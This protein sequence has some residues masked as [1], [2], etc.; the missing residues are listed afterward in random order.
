MN[1]NGVI[2]NFLVRDNEIEEL[3]KRG[4]DSTFHIATHEE[5]SELLYASIQEYLN[6]LIFKKNE[7]VVYEIF[8]LLEQVSIITNEREK[9]ISIKNYV[10]EIVKLYEMNLYNIGEIKVAINNTKGSYGKRIVLEKYW[11]NPEMNP[12]FINFIEK[13]PYQ[14]YKKIR[15]AVGFSIQEMIDITTKC[16]PNIKVS[17]EE[18]IFIENPKNFNELNKYGAILGKILQVIFNE[19]VFKEVNSLIDEVENTI[20]SLKEKNDSSKFYYFKESLEK[21]A[22][23]SNL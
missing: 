1:N 10:L 21:M 7:Y 20:Y 12:E 22:K 6:N 3:K 11:E 2:C 14:Y 4:Y 18:I 15:E 9:I 17:E 13:E 5:Y 16:F 23:K 8:D 19:D